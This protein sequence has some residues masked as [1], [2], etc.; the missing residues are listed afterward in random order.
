[1]DEQGQESI[2]NVGCKLGYRLSGEGIGTFVLSEED[3]ENVVN[4]REEAGYNVFE[5][6][7]PRKVIVGTQSVDDTS[8]L[9]SVKSLPEYRTKLSF[10]V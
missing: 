7:N 6:H 4:R 9:Y 1:V 2:W 5:L 8:T 3:A 10:I